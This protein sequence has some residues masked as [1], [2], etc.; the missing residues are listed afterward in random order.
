MLYP[1]LIPDQVLTDILDNLELP[2]NEESYA[3]VA[4]LSAR[5]AFDKFLTWHGIIGYTDKII[6][7]LD[8]CRYAEQ[9]QP[10]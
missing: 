1:E 2:D 6:A 3:K 7:A 5:D 8:G 4:K 9:Q 10:D